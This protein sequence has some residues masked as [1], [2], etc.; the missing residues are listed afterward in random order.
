ML[1][2][3]GFIGFNHDYDFVALIPALTSLWFYASRRR[4]YWGVVLPLVLLFFC[5]QRL[6]HRL[7]LPI[8]DHW[9]TVIVL[10][11]LWAILDFS[12]RSR[13]NSLRE[14]G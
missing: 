8:F 7:G 9:R 3:F 13:S 14:E 6:V 1:L 5:P 2:T 12:M 11:M 10:L 4:V